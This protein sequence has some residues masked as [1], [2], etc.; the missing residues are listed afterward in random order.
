[1]EIELN[2]ML[3]VY[4][5]GSLIENIIIQE[6]KLLFSDVNSENNTVYKTVPVNEYEEGTDKYLAAESVLNFLELY[7]EEG[8]KN[9]K[10]CCCLMYTEGNTSFK[11]EDYSIDLEAI[12][13]DSEIV[14]VK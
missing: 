5:E 3:L 13:K 1:M 12:E 14:I 6:D 2:E 10:N 11:F 9:F 7:S 4:I 8:R